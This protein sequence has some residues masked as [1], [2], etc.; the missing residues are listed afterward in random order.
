MLHTGMEEC[1]GTVIDFQGRLLCKQRFLIKSC[2]YILLI[3]NFI[4]IY[5]TTIIIIIIYFPGDE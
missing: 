3:T 4:Q 5:K 2:R 1:M